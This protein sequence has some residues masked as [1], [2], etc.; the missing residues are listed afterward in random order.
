MV[1]A[2]TTSET[3]QKPE[4]AA[5]VL[6]PPKQEDIDQMKAVLEFLDDKGARG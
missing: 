4:T 6:T 5:E 2:V 1:E 3:G